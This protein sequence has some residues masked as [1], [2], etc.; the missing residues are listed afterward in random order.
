MRL[1]AAGRQLFGVRAMP[2]MAILGTLFGLCTACAAG[3]TPPPHTGD[4]G[5]QALKELEAE[6]FITVLPPGATLSGPIEWFPATYD[7][8]TG[9]WKGPTFTV[10]FD[11]SQEPQSVLA[12]YDHRASSLGWTSVSSTNVGHGSGGSWQ[13]RYR[14]GDASVV[15]QNGYNLVTST[16]SPEAFILYGIGPVIQPTKR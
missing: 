14:D 9:Q 16:S 4:P 1:L 13:K 11:D 2:R 7:P 15:L 3:V 12:F 5:N 10:V 6:R 8:T